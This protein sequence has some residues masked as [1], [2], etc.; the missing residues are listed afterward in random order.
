MSNSLYKDT[1][2]TPLSFLYSTLSLK[3][4]LSLSLSLVSASVVEHSFLYGQN[5]RRKIF[6]FIV[7]AEVRN[8]T[9]LRY[10]KCIVLRKSFLSTTFVKYPFYFMISVV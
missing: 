3:N 7:S 4:S 10:V 6:T 1:F 5:G 2:V 9:F 8:S